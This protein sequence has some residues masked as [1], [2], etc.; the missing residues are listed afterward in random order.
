MTQ[1]RRKTTSTNQRG[2]GKAKRPTTDQQVNKTDKQKSKKK[3]VK[4]QA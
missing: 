2:Y 3:E 1:I 4:R